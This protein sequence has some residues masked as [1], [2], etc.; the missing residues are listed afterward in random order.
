MI[1]EDLRHS[2][3]QSQHHGGET[4]SIARK[5]LQLHAHG[6][7]RQPNLEAYDQKLSL[8]WDI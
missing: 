6:R 5:K 8:S 2:G 1:R 7:R 4:S 3:C